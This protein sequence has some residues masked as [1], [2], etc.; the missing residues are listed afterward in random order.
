MANHPNSPKQNNKPETALAPIPKERA[1]YLSEAYGYRVEQIE[2]IRGAICIGATDAELEFFLATC[3]RVKLDPFARQIWFVKRKQRIEDAN[4]NAEYKLVGKPE[5]SIDGLR[6]IAERTG[7]YEGQAPMLW[8]GADGKWIDVWLKSEPPVAARA[9]VFRKSFREPMVAVALFSEL[10]P[11]F[12]N[13]DIGP[14][15]KKM[16]ANQLAKCAEALALRKAFPRDLSGMHTDT[17]MEHVQAS[18]SYVAPPAAKPA[19]APASEAKQ[20]AAAKPAE[21]AADADVVDDAETEPAEPPENIGE[22]EPLDDLDR[23]MK[24]LIAEVRAAEKRD[25]LSNVGQ[26]I[27]AAKAKIKAG[28][29]DDAHANSIVKLVAPEL[30]KKWRELKPATGSKR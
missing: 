15:W 2:V 8:C 11:K 20:I 22:G 9:T 6:T 19:V 21:P 16:A 14:M 3:V 30:E 17:E 5:T 18:V 7:E 27:S 13:G 29:T 12:P 23:E 24:R 26:M 28:T 25:D 1:S 10:C 4:G